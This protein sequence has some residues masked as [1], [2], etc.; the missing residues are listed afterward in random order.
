ME[1]SDWVALGALIVTGVSIYF[2]YRGSERR[3]K[4]QLAHER[5][6]AMITTAARAYAKAH[7][8]AMMSE[9]EDWSQSAVDDLSDDLAYVRAMTLTSRLELAA[10]WLDMAVDDAVRAASD[11][12]AEFDGYQKAVSEVLEKYREAL[13]ETAVT[14]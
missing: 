7:K 4:R 14:S 9:P 8:L 12:R 1:G 11:D 5:R 2:N 13:R 6:E 3:H 10:L